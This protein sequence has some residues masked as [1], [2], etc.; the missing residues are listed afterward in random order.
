E[1]DVGHPRP[2]LENGFADLGLLLGRQAGRGA[3]A[4][5]A[6][7]RAGTRLGASLSGRSTL[8]VTLGRCTSRRGIL[9]TLRLHV[10]L[11]RRAGLGVGRSLRA[12][13]AAL[14]LL[15]ALH[16]SATLGLELTALSLQF[17]TT[18]GLQLAALLLHG[19]LLLNAR[20][21]RGSRL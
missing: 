12:G 11:G 8:H 16:F 1:V 10:A 19:A 6:G 2:G 18:L 4:A 17:R 7:G 9:A 5:L 15:A 14:Q 13:L 20:A 21:A 3:G